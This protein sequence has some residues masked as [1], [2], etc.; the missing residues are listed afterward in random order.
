MISGK[1]GQWFQVIIIT[2]ASIIIIDY[3]LPKLFIRFILTMYSGPSLSIL[4]LYAWVSLFMAALIPSYIAKRAVISII[5]D[6]N[7]AKKTYTFTF[8]ISVLIWGYIN[9]FHS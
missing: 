1:T 3:I 4:G 8:I 6:Q 9:F 2:I 7:T 5:N